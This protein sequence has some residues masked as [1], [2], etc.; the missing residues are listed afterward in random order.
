MF[1]LFVFMLL[2][3]FLVMKLNDILGMRIGFKIEED[4]LR[5][6]TKSADNEISEVDGKMASVLSVYPKFD[7]NDF[8]DKSKRAFEMIFTAY[9]SGDDK[10]LK[11]LLCPRIFQAFSMAINDR[12]I[13]GEILEG[14]LVRIISAEIIDS[15]VVDD[16]VC[17]VVKFVT[18]QSNV[19]RS[20][21]GKIIEGN[22]DFVET[23]TDVWSF[24]RNRSSKSL[25]WYLQEIKSN[26]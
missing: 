9:A 20:A 25:R 7:A 6:F 8:L 15:S 13:R 26:E 23:R 1:G 21:D 16:D 14:I 11:E 3:F 22:S 17:V 5:D 12:K 2:T 10:I 18:E 4:K 24:L 19:L